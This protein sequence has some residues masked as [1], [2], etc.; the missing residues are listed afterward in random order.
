M[1]YEGAVR[2]SKSY[3]ANDAFLARCRTIPPSNILVSGYSSNSVARNVIAEWKTA[4]GPEKFKTVKADKDE[5]LIISHEGL[6]DHK[7]YVRGSGK[8]NDF[9]QIQGATFGAWYSDELTRHHKSFLDMALTRLSS[10][11]SFGI[12]TMNPDN[13]K[14]QV[15]T[16][17]I[18]N[19]ELYEEDENGYSLYKKVH[20][21][22]EDNPSLSD[23]Y[24]ETLKNSF[25]GVFYKR[26]ILGQWVKAEGLIYSMFDPDKHILT[27][28]QMPERYQ[29][30]RIGVDY[31]SQN[32]CT[33]GLWS[34]VGQKWY[35]RAEYH[36]SGREKGKIKTNS[37]Y[38]EDMKTFFIDNQ[39]PKNTP[40]IV[41]RSAAGFKEDLRRA[42][43]QVQNGNNKVLKG[44][45]NLSNLL[46]KGL[47]YFC[48][49]CEETINELYSYAWD[50]KKG[51]KGQDEPLKEN[52]HHM[53]GD[54]YALN[55]MVGS[56]R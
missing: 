9:E 1:F 20:F 42:R 2:S 43:F 4:L 7:F 36:Y 54:R 6:Q 44:I 10:E 33:F 18:D 37:E 46:G 19:S 41:D 24:K 35:K 45:Q 25:K 14:H 34:R 12:A 30:H 49:E 32:P 21:D 55:T 16:D 5:Y 47:I 23:E 8:A 31:G 29:E 28:D 22:L 17:F 51:E 15:K 56:M 11:H 26:Y 52:D 50:E 48:S 39:I 40:V 27:P 53:D 38:V 3:T 13:P